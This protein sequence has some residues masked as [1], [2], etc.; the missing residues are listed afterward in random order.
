[1]K[2]Q[3]LPFKH[4]IS[5]FCIEDNELW[6]LMIDQ[7]LKQ[8]ADFR[9]YTYPSAEAAMK[10]LYLNPDIILLDYYLPGMNGLETIR[11]LKYHKSDIPVFILSSQEEV[12]V[13]L[14]LIKEGVA[15]YYTKSRFSPQQLYE[16]IWRI[17]YRNE[18][19]KQSSAQVKNVLGK[20]LVALVIL[21]ILSIAYYFY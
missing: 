9:I 7:R 10:D 1:V 14:D 8:I 21:I 4:K 11:K 20:V 15:A 3:H 13:T 6:S 2:E 17:S 5:I 16:D 19:L 12:D 18:K